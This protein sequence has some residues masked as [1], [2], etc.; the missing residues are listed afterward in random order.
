MVGL[1]LI[2]TGLVGILN[3]EFHNIVCDYQLGMV[4]A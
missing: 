4:S 2:T 3:V 1:L